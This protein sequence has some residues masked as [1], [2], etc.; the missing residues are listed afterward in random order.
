[1]ILRQLRFMATEVPRTL[2]AVWCNGLCDP[3][4]VNFRCY[5][6]SSKGA[7]LL[8]KEEWDRYLKSLKG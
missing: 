5:T 7:I 6:E 8:S 3:C 1:M 4:V 2:E